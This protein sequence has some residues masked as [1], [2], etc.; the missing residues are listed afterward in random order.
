LDPSLQ[1]VCFTSFFST[2]ILIAQHLRRQSVY[3]CS[4][5][6]IIIIIIRKTIES[7]WRGELCHEL[8]QSVFFFFFSVW[9]STIKSRVVA[10]TINQPAKSIGPLYTTNP[11]A[12]FSFLFWAERDRDRTSA[13]TK[14][15]RVKR[16]FSLLCQSQSYK[17]CDKTRNLVY[18]DPPPIPPPVYTVQLLLGT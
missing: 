9:L 13:R 2:N 15:K 8:F 5:L 18:L 17:K 10:T 12:L 4:Y 6:F 3:W 1:E 7:K 16:I 14:L 11:S